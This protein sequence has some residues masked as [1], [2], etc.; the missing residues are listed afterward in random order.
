MSEEKAKLEGPD[1]TQGV[2]LSTIPNGSMLLGHARGEPVLLVRRGDE[3]FAIGAICTHYGAPLEQGLLVGDTVRCPWHHACFSLHTG[4]ALRAPALD[5]VSCWRVEEVRDLARQF[6]PVEQRIGAVYVREKLSR[7]PFSA[8]HG[9]RITVVI[10]GGGAAGNAAAET[11]RHEG[12]SSS[13]T[14]L[15]A[16]ESIPCDRPNLS[17]GYL[18][19]VASDES[20]LLRSAKFYKDHNIDLHL[21][22]RV[23]AIDIR[24]RFVELADGSRH[25]YGMLLLATGADPVRLEIPGSDLPHVHYLRTLADSRA[26]VSKALA[27]RR[28]V[29]IGASFIGL[30]VAA[31]LRARNIEVHVVGPETIPM[32]KILGPEVGSFI[33]RLHEEHGVTFHLGTT[34]TSIDERS[35]TLKNGEKLQADIVVVGIGVRPATSLAE[36]AGLAVD[37]GVTVDE[38]LETSAPGVFAAGDIARWPDRLTGERIRVEHFVV[39]ERQGQTA[40]RNI[41]GHRERFDAVPFFWTE[42]YD[43]GLGYVGHAE[44]WDKAEIKGSLDRRD[45]TIT[46]RRAGK[47]LAVAVVHRDLEGLRAEVEFERA[48]TRNN[49]S[50]QAVQGSASTRDGA[51]TATAGS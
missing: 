11:L 10:V 28:A 3:L 26:L 7:Q 46:Y 32:E 33:R 47:K 16:D 17:K 1:L 37:R 27:S 40:A 24:S 5:S 13:I 31:S 14:M 22:A 44:R 9:N 39:A 43:F 20:N 15:S 42:Q 51:E 23:A 48:M 45:C 34:A 6:T 41:L 4:E 35:V 36:R 19:G 25:S 12:Y 29:V 49:S 38:Y 2:E 30:E 50:T 21:G 8:M 18:A